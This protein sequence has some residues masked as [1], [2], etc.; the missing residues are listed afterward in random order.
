MEPNILKIKSFETVIVGDFNLPE[1]LWID[2]YGSSK[3]QTTGSPFA[4][5]LSNNYLYQTM[6]EPTRICSDQNSS[7]LD[8][9]IVSSP[10]ILISNDNLLPPFGKSNHVTILPIINIYSKQT[11]YKH[12]SCIDYKALCRDL[13]CVNWSFTTDDDL[14]SSWHIFKTLLLGAESRHTSIK[15]IRLP[16]TLPYLTIFICNL[17]QRK[18][19]V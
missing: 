14:E 2:G 5:C 10:E 4:C 12:H 3:I 13:A 9:L 16:K 19:K 8:L 7:L 1:I 15:M 6:N 11:T 17:I 18:S